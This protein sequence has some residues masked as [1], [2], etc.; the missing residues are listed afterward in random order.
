MNVQRAR[1]GLAA[2][3]PRYESIEANSGFISLDASAGQ[4]TRFEAPLP[5]QQPQ[6]ASVDAHAERS[7]AFL[8]GVAMNKQTVSPGEAVTIEYTIRID[9]DAF[10]RI[11]DPDL[12]DLGFFQAGLRIDHE[13]RLGSEVVGSASD[14][15][16]GDTTFQVDFFAPEEPGTYTVNINTMGANSGN[17][18]GTESITF[19]VVADGG[20][21]GIGPGNGDGTGDQDGDGGLLDGGL[22]SGDIQQTLV[23]LIV[24][25][26]IFAVST[27]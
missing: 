1:S 26:G 9:P 24:V 3:H 13:V 8:T 7:D 11:V 6:L 5:V 25:L 10:S 23:L 27:Q 14:C 22:F 4:P 15:Y 19:D 17:D 20:G 2:A 12:C 21:G 16:G 18:L